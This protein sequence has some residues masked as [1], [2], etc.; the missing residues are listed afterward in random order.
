LTSERRVAFEHRRRLLLSLAAAA[1]AVAVCAPFGPWQLT[2]LAAWDAF[3]V[4]YMANIW[5]KIWRLDAPTTEHMSTVQDDGRND[6][7][8]MLLTSAALTSLA[9]A[10]LGVL[11]ARHEGGALGDLLGVV[12]VATVLLSWALIHT[13][14]TLHYARLYYGDRDGGI[15]F[16]GGEPPDYRDFAYLAFT[17]GMTYQVSDTNIESR[18]IRRSLLGHSLLSY[19]FGTVIIA[20]TINLVAS[21]VS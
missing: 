13:L 10:G 3:V 8:R 21:L 19:L 9:G 1:V 4:A 16:P 14:Y 20:V 7:R 15:D 12:T 2:V 11:K 5:A 17:I 18:A 6:T